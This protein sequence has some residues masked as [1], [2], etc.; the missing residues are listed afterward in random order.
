MSHVS[1]ASELTRGGDDDGVR[2]GGI[3]IRRGRVAGN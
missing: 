1:A 3:E 2:F